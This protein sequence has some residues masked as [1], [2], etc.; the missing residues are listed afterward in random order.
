MD[1]EPGRN[2]SVRELSLPLNNVKGWLKFLGVLSI[3]YGIIIA[4]TMVGIL[5][6]WLPIWLGVLLYQAG[7]AAERAYEAGDPVAMTRAL[8]K[9]RVYFIV[10]GVIAL[11]G[12]LI[13]GLGTLMGFGGMMMM[14]FGGATL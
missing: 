8:N 3:I 1:T 10:L 2:P 14:G 7:R 12:L 4:L 5:I 9:L 11:I 13:M 6:A